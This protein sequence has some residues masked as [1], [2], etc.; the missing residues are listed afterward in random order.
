[1]YFSFAFTRRKRRPIDRVE[2]ELR[3]ERLSVPPP[4]CPRPSNM[5]DRAKR[6]AALPIAVFGESIVRTILPQYF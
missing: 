2:R 1:M 6:Y 5:S 4:V 3:E